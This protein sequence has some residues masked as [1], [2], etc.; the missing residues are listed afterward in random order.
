MRTLAPA[1]LLCAT[2]LASPGRAQAPPEAGGSVALPAAAQSGPMAVEQALQR[3]RSVRAFAPT[4]LTPADVAQLLWAAQGRT[5]AQGHRTAP[6]AGALYPLDVLL[7]AGRVEGLP[8]GLYRYLPDGHRLQPGATGD[9]RAA[10][11][12]ATRGQAWVAQAPALLVIVAD[13]QRSTPRYGARAERY[14]S[15]E[16]GHAAQNVYLQ[17]TARGLG[18]TIVGAF[19]DQALRA[20]LGLTAAH[21]PLAV[22]PV[23]HPR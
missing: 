20:A 23:G 3:R 1:A 21:V 12:A 2:L 7:V 19:D 13:P 10:V 18:T 14:L 6:S 9:L 5:D 4:P 17:A 8:A 16:A 22:L 11:A 15:I